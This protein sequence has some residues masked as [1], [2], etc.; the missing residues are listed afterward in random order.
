MG[1]MTARLTH[2][3]AAVEK[4]AAGAHSGEIERRIGQ[5]LR[6]LL[7]SH[8][9][10]LLA[11]LA[12]KAVEPDAQIERMNAL[13]G[14][15]VGVEFKEELSVNGRK[16]P[17]HVDPTR[18]PPKIQLHR[19]LIEGIEDAEVLRAFH[20]PIA[21]ILGVSPVGVGLVLSSQDER[22]LKVLVAQVARRAGPQR[23]RITQIE[24]I[25]EQR[26]QLFN[27]RLDA[28]ADSFG[29]NL[30]WHR[31][32]ED[33]FKSQLA[34]TQN[35]WPDWDGVQGRPFIRGVIGELHEFIQARKDMPRAELLVELCWESL[36]LSPQSFLRHAAQTLRAKE[37]DYC[38][39]GALHKLAGAIEIECCEAF[40]SIDAWPAYRGLGEAWDALFRAEQTMLPGV[41][42][43]RSTP[44]MSVL[45]RPIESLGI[46]EPS[47]LPWDAPLLAWSVREHH[48]LRDLL[49]GLRNALEEQPSGA[50]E[51]IIDI[52][53]DSAE[54]PLEI[55]QPV[56]GL[57]VGIN[58]CGRHALPDDYNA[59]LTRAMNACHAAMAARFEE[60]DALGKLR[61][62]R[63]LRSAYDGYFGSARALWKR[64]FQAWEKW[65]AERAFRV[66]STEIRY[67]AGPA[68]L[69]DPFDS[70][71]SA[72]LTSVPKFIL[73]APRPEGFEGLPV[74]MPIAALKK[75]M[76]G[77]PICV[78][79]VD[80]REAQDC[81]WVGDIS[82]TLA[83]VEEYPT[84][85]VLAAI[86]RDSV[87]LLIEGALIRDAHSKD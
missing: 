29:E 24:A 86:E 58:Q 46:C 39:V 54:A 55:R 59:L 66:L 11:L 16:I 12:E 30:F 68:M 38:L 73:V 9:E 42:T 8:S 27:A 77:A 3:P 37:G 19:K 47:T 84:R 82:V 7:G 61:A 85:V 83:T 43:R 44:L 4:Q 56:D 80:V 6:G 40:Y 13:V 60:L 36:E 22:Q 23:V 76:L 81:A 64:R 26:V 65:P 41:A 51:F 17:L 31:A 15:L 71:E 53:G 33:D 63:T 32:G 45:D 78:R 14:A 28:V 57:Q 48:G 49:V 79:L 10:V 35:G 21:D 1:D 2:A 72:D 50:T 70:P 52:T 20:A 69:F 5:L 67:I 62:L 25:V 18:T 75:S 87:R 34:E 74:P